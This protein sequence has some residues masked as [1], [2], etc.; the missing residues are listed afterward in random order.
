MPSW[1]Y[2]ISFVSFFLG[3]LVA[4]VF[5]MVKQP[6]FSMSK[7]KKQEAPVQPEQT[8]GLKPQDY[9]TILSDIDLG[10]VA[11]DESKRLV[12]HNQTALAMLGEACS[13]CADLYDFLTVFGS[14]NGLKAGQLLGKRSLH[15]IYVHENR[16][17]LLDYQEIQKDMHSHF[18][19][20]TTYDITA[21]EALERQRKQFVSN[22]SHELKTPLTTIMTYT[23]S[24]LDW[25]LAEQPADAVHRDVKRIYDD[26]VRMN[27]LV[28]DLSTLSTIDGSGMRLRLAEINPLHVA[29]SCVE[30][31][32]AV[33][34]KKE[35][36]LDLISAT[37][38]PVM[39]GEAGSV[40]R[41]LRN[42]IENAIKYSHNH[43]EVQIYVNCIHDEIYIKVK[44]NGIGIDKDNLPFIFNR[45]FRVDNSG[46]T[47]LGGT[48]LGLA[49]AKELAEL[50]G[51]RITVSS[52]P[53]VGTEFI[54]FLPTAERVCREYIQALR[55][56]HPKTGGYY[57]LLGE[58]LLAQARSLH[59]EIK[60]LTELSPR[61]LE[62]LVE[63]YIA[64]GSNVSEEQTGEEKEKV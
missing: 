16:S 17:I 13:N 5:F 31:L 63:P 27:N 40:E 43:S 4:S 14:D 20:V 45:F 38:V 3:L 23:E 49:I 58:K 36:E 52:T 8:D 46:S 42:L 62:S 32:K 44:D 22:V 56:G 9:A 1:D 29:R 61:E 59:K 26:A 21:R 6:K 15:G 39:L 10:V 34:K 57:D 37:G 24:L 12:Y 2:L 60:S 35:I 25:G 47:L 11:F 19:T 33:A 48:G 54:V 50:H 51:G 64:P 30:N 55:S 53:G 7:N 41:I 18:T 28:K